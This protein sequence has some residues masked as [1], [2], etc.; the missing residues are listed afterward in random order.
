MNVRLEK[1]EFS[2]YADA[3]SALLPKL[4][5]HVFHVTTPQ[6]YAGIQKDGFVGSNS[7]EKYSPTCSQSKVSYFRRQGCVSLVD[8]RTI[9]DGALDFGILKYNFLNPFSSNQAVLLLLSPDA[10]QSLIPWDD[11]DRRNCARWWFRNLKPAF[12]T[13]FHLISLKARFI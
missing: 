12:R 8:L 1:L 7:D 5:G 11:P 10:Y 4:R 2:I 3:R 9:S 13:G 6:G